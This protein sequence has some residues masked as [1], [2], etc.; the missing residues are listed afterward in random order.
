MQINDAKG[1]EFG[2]LTIAEDGALVEC[3]DWM[4]GEATCMSTMP[5]GEAGFE[6]KEQG[7]KTRGQLFLST[8]GAVQLTLNDA[9]ERPRIAFKVTAEGKAMVQTPDHDK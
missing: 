2:G 8:D 3:F 5:S 7:G 6:V 9:G 1:N 4:H